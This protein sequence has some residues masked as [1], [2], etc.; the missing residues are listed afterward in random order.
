MATMK[1]T[2]ARK[3]ATISAPAPVSETAQAVAIE[4]LARLLGKAGNRDA[5][6]DGTTA[7]V[8]FQLAATVDLGSRVETLVR[9]GQATLTVGHETTRASSTTPDVAGL[10]GYLLDQLGPKARAAALAGLP[11]YFAANGELPAVSEARAAEAEIL[12][13]GLRASKPQTVRG[14]VGVVGGFDA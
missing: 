12:L 11:V 9:T 10:V 1:T 4:A 6:A 3:S 13:K 14:A 5:I 2:V 7:A 8:K